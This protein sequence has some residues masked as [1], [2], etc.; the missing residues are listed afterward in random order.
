MKKVRYELKNLSLDE[1]RSIILDE[2]E[3]IIFTVFVVDKIE[4]RYRIEKPNN[5]DDFMSLISNK[6][7]IGVDGVDS[8]SFNFLECDFLDVYFKYPI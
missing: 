1:L 2:R 7:S 5:F 4:T 8:G 3:T 6:L